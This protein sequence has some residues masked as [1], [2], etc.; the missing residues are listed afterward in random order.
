MKKIKNRVVILG[1]GSFIASEFIKLLKKNKINFLPITKK[2]I[3]FSKNNSVK[4]LSHVIKKNDAIVFIS[5][6]A[7]VKNF[8]MLIEN[9]NICKNI[10]TVLIKKK[11]SYLLYVSSDAVYSD[12]KKPLTEN[13][14]TNPDNLHGFMHLMRESILKLLNTKICI[15]RPTLVYGPNDP[16]NGYG[17]NQFVRLAQSKKS[18][19][20]FG[21]GEER[22][23]HINVK[24]VGFAIYSLL[25]KK[26]VGTVNIVTGQ[27]YSFYQ[28]ANKIKKLY[29]V[30]V[31]YLKRNGPMPHKGYRAFNNR[32]IKKL[33]LK[34]NF[35]NVLRWLEN[36]ENYK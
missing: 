1:S 23:D 14:K 31:K 4:K 19:K 17:P 15:I 3:N 5:A 7:P 27:V 32:L 16:H 25:N 8:K 26:Y 21:K 13:S 34:N 36:K 6:V 35:I 24:D 12:S 20:I 29:K 9:L 28:I 33:I 30:K 11:I 22:R 10:F 2:R 18:V